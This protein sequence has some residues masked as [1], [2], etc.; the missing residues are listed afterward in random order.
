MELRDSIPEKPMDGYINRGFL[1]MSH[2]LS[3]QVDGPAYAL[4]VL[5]KH[6]ILRNYDFNRALG[7]SSALLQEEK[8]VTPVKWCL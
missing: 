4:R 5:L 6:A 2:A 8:I 1:E 7:A 3:L